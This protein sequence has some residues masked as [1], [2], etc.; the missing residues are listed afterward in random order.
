M[1]VE[2]D[3]RSDE[4]SITMTVRVTGFDDGADGVTKYHVETTLPNGGVCVGRRR[5]NEVIAL[6]AELQPGLDFPDKIRIFLTSDA[7]K[8]KRASALEQL[9]QEA[10]TRGCDTELLNYFLGVDDGEMNAA[11][12]VMAASEAAAATAAA[13]EAAAATAAAEAVAAK[14]AAQAA[15]AREAAEAAAA[16]EA[17]EK[18]AAEDRAAA[19]AMAVADAK[20]EAE[21]QTAREAAVEAKKAEEAEAA[22]VCVAAAFAAGVGVF[23]A[24]EAAARAEEAA[25]RAAEEAA[26]AAALG[27]VPPQGRNGCRRRPSFAAGATR[28]PLRRP[29]RPPVP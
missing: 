19:E 9:L 20:A 27:P 3:G 28:T 13:E 2:C 16:R 21:A 25:A 11:L 7:V 14:V 29:W 23:E 10:V 5:F 15:A 18:A 24:A 8:Q 1:S 26:A 6:H 12:V 17:A 22:A 4:P